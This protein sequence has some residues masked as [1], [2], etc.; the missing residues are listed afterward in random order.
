MSNNIKIFEL[1]KIENY[2]QHDVSIIYYPRPALSPSI[3]VRECCQHPRLPHVYKSVSCQSSNKFI[4]RGCFPSFAQLQRTPGSGMEHRGSSCL[5]RQNTT[6]NV[7]CKPVVKNATVVCPTVNKCHVSESIHPVHVRLYIC[8]CLV[9][10]K[11]ISALA[12][13]SHPRI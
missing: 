4:I 9:G 8:E 3:D 12:G 6:E 2:R 11:K 13:S 1:P 5:C 7:R 10:R